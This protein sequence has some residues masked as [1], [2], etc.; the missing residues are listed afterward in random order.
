M[1]RRSGLTAAV[2]VAAFLLQGC[3]IIPLTSLTPS[4]QEVTI[5]P[6]GWFPKKILLIDVDGAITTTG[7]D[8]PFTPPNLVAQIDEQLKAAARDSSIRAV[9]LRI[10]SPGGGVTA[11]D[12]LYRRLAKFREETNIPVYAAMFGL[13]A[14][15]GY[16]IAMAADKVY[17]TPTTVTGSIGVIAIFPEGEGLLNKIGVNFNIIKSG[18][19]KDMGSLFRRMKPDEQKILQSVIESMYGRFVEVVEKGRPDLTPD[20]IRE[21]ADGRIYTAQQAYENGL[22][23]GVKHLDEVIDEAEAAAGLHNARVV[24]YRRAR[25]GSGSL[26]AQSPPEAWNSSE[27]LSQRLLNPQAK[28]SEVN[29]INLGSDTDWIR[30]SYFYYLWVP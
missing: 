17:A 22:I 4:Y 20:R 15:G 1:I 9:V 16:Y 5:R 10:N 29:L 21:L 25:M 8:S 14:S 26:Y 30:D 19:F 18:E 28:P 13:A 27:G 23:D 7:N 12:V 6:G 11:S 2:V 3:I 24:A